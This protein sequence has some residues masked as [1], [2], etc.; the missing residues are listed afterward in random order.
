MQN[1]SHV[2]NHVS[3]NY[4]QVK[5]LKGV[6]SQ[7]TQGL[8]KWIHDR[9]SSIKK[10]SLSIFNLKP[11]KISFRHT[12]HSHSVKENASYT[13]IKLKNCRNNQQPAIA[14]DLF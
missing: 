7:N 9:L 8:P 11:Q 3:Q 10:T 1:I 13:N 12:L 4:K 5:L 14:F 2:S 6:T